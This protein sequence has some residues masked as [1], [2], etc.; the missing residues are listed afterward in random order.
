MTGLSITDVE[1]IVVNVP[2]TPRCEEWNARE[3]WQ[4]R[5]TE[6]IRVTTDAG[7]VGYGETIL[8]YTWGRVPDEAIERIE[9]GVMPDWIVVAESVPGEVGHAAI[10]S[11]TRATPL[12]RIV[13]LLGSL[14]EGAA[15]TGRPSL[16]PSCR[17]L[18]H[19]T[20]QP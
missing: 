16:Y 8:H 12:T 15:R 10:K 7:I 14:C 19:F 11:L 17:S 4:W 2:L 3:V 5:I 20:D 9:A 1:R 13:G 6:L 18:S